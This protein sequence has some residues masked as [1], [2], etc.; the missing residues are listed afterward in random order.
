[1]AVDVN[2]ERAGT[3]HPRDVRGFGSRRSTRRARNDP[4]A[5][6]QTE[7]RSIGDPAEVQ[8]ADQR[9]YSEVS[10]NVG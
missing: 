5:R 3:G 6:D 9:V 2:D 10:I 8:V 7:G 1:M 4:R